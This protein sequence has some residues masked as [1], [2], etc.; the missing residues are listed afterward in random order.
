MKF[1]LSEV[2]VFSVNSVPRQSHPKTCRELNACPACPELVEGSGVEGS[3]V[4]PNTLEGT[5]AKPARHSS[6]QDLTLLY[7]FFYVNRVNSVS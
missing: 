1:M 6:G 7:N 5:Q 3:N 2:E 4:P